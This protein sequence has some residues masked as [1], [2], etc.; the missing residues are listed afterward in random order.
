M[1]KRFIGCV[2]AIMCVVNCYV[3]SFANP[4]AFDFAVAFTQFAVRDM[5][6]LFRSLGKNMARGAISGHLNEGMWTIVRWI[7]VAKMM[8]KK[9]RTIRT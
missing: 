5:G 1:K 6:K 2:I 3:P 9:I 8:K 7:L 4:T